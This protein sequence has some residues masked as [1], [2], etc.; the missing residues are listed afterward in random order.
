MSCHQ[1]ASQGRLF[2][3]LYRPFAHDSQAAVWSGGWLEKWPNY[4]FVFKHTHT[5]IYTH[6]EC[7]YDRAI[8]RNGQILSLSRTNTTQN[9]HSHRRR[10]DCN[11]TSITVGQN[12]LCQAAMCFIRN[13]Y[14]YS[15]G[16]FRSLWRP[17]LAAWKT[18]NTWLSLSYIFTKLNTLLPALSRELSLKNL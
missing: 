11:R 5:H 18:S 1:G 7:I 15:I 3:S 14:V 6:K 16:G 13:I 2:K 8:N 12:S 9:T 10:C 17:V 4:Y